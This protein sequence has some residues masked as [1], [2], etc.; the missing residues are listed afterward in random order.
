MSTEL[1]DP[2]RVAKAKKLIYAVSIVVPIVVA[3]LF[4]IPPIEGLDFSFLPPIYATLNGAT[5]VLLIFA[6]VAIKQK[7]MRLH[8]LLMQTSLVLSL[9]FLLCYIAYHITSLPTPYGGEFGMIYYPLL[10]AHIFLSVAVIPLVLLS[11]LWAWAG[12]F[13][14]H[15]K[16]TRFSF[17]IWL[18]VAVSGV[19]VY[20]MISPYY[21]A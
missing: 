15:K 19:V 12:D 17:P 21:G 13:N 20:M 6:L 16:W 11:Y 14:R 2:N 10:I 9:V 18:F 7:N 8:A 3:V 4:S 5:A 1:K